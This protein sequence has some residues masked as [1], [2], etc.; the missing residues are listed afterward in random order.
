M[1][2]FENLLI[3]VY[4]DIEYAV[5]MCASQKMMVAKFVDSVKDSAKLA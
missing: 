5:V 3:P 2:Y 4:G 1:Y